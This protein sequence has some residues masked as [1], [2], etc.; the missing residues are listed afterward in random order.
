MKKGVFQIKCIL[1]LLLFISSNKMTKA[2]LLDSDLKSYE[3]QIIDSLRS[4]NE[5]TGNIDSLLGYYKNKIYS[6]N[7]FPQPNKKILFFEI[8]ITSAHSRKY[9]AIIYKRKLIIYKSINFLNDF[10]D[11][12]NQIKNIPEGNFKVEG[13]IDLLNK[14]ANI[15]KYNISL[16]WAI[17]VV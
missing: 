2:Q 1:F 14:I 9:L 12:N 10:F 8:G 3:H 17:K 13:I 5:I 15:Y 7:L 4:F 6:R 16:P 11:I